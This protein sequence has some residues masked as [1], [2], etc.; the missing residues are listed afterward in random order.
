MFGYLTGLSLLVGAVV[1]SQKEPCPPQFIIG[2]TYNE[3]RDTVCPDI[4]KQATIAS[5]DGIHVGYLCPSKQ[6]MVIGN[7]QTGKMDGF[8]L[9]RPE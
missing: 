7:M 6:V 8:F 3:I 2:T 1:L 5:P 9:Y 4:E